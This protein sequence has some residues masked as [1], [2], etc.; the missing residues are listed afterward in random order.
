M[1]DLFLEPKVLDYSGDKYELILLTLRWAKTMKAKGS[2][3]PMA[4]LVEKALRDIIDNKVTKDEILAIKLPE[5]VVEEKPAV[6]SVADQGT[7]KELKL[8]LPP[9]DE[10]AEKKKA[11]KKK[12]KDGEE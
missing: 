6:I 7:D 5:P 3:E 11:K 9:D 10:E 8:P 4:A 1:T 2:P 12:K